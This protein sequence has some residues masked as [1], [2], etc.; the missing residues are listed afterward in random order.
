MEEISAG[1]K[2]LTVSES[3]IA[4]EKLPVELKSLIC[5]SLNFADLKSLRQVSKSWTLRSSR[6]SLQRAR[7]HATNS[8]TT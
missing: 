3:A 4:M 7:N 6:S 5:S 8:P 2:S 1:M